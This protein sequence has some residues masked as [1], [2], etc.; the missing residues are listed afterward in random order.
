M[1]EG[2]KLGNG[3]SWREKKQEMHFVPLHTR[4][5]CLALWLW[6]LPGTWLPLVPERDKLPMGSDFGGGWVLP[7]AIVFFLQRTSKQFYDFKA[8][9]PQIHPNLVSRIPST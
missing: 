8:H 6:H 2:A 3:N 1:L 9:P 5:E 7:P 4:R